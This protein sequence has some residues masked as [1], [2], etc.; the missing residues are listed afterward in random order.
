MKDD[1]K[2]RHTENSFIHDAS[3]VR[4]RRSRTGGSRKDASKQTER[5]RERRYDRA[6]GR[7]TDFVNPTMSPTRILE[8]LV[9]ADDDDCV[10]SGLSF[11][12]HRHCPNSTHKD[13]IYRAYRRN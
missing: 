10:C 12:G 1:I 9:T 3:S 5:E 7:A 13:T 8:T 2:S 4:A 11:V 6:R